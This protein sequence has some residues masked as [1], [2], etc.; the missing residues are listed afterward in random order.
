MSLFIN[1]NIKMNNNMNNNN[2]NFKNTYLSKVSWITLNKNGLIEDPNVILNDKAAIYIYQ[3][4]KDKSEI[5]IGSTNNINKRI[6]KH[7][8]SVNQGDRTC[9]KFYN[10]IRKHGWYNFRLG[11]LEYI[12]LPSIKINEK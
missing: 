8:Y 2:L 3:F 10:Y 12:S 6:K 7:R 1:N 5:Y 11:I 4:I 9:P